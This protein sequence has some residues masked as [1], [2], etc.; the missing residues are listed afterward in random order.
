MS[1]LYRFFQANSRLSA[2]FHRRRDEELFFRYDQYVDGALAALPAQALVVDLGGGRT[3]AFAD[4]LPDTHDIT[5]VAVDV[6]EDELRANTTAHETLVADVSRHIPFDDSEVDLL[7]SRTL[8]E[9]VPDIE[10]AAKEMARVL[11]PGSQSIHI[12]PCRYALFAL[13]ARLLPFSFA[14][15]VLHLT[16]PE[17]RD[18]IEFDVIYDHG[19]PRAL[20]RV[21]S[22]AGFRDV[23][24]ECVWDQAAYFHPFFPLF[25]VVLLYQRLAEACRA[26]LLASYVIVRAIR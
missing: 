15:R 26:R 20:E 25:L 7:V 1:L 2:R 8:L 18:V 17:A 6:S 19:H 12:L 24:V 13:V 4:R 16:I 23:E 22:V 11:R 9:H 5:V 14:K 3:S 10:S 21:F